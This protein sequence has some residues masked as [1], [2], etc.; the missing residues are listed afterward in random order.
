MRRYY[1]PPLICLLIMALLF[2]S[3]EQE[4]HVVLPADPEPLSHP[5][6]AISGMPNFSSTPSSTFLTWIDTQED[7]HHLMMTE[8]DGRQWTNAEHIASGKD[9]FVNW[10]DFP[11]SVH[12][13]NGNKAAYWLQ[14]SGEGTF[15]YDI[16]WKYFRA[17]EWSETMLLNTDGLQAEHGFASMI[18]LKDGRMLVSWLDGRLT[19]TEKHDMESHDH[20]GHAGSMTLRAALF[21]ADFNRLEEWSLDERVCDCCQTTL[22]PTENGAVLL[23]RDRSEEEIRDISVKVFDGRAW[24]D[25]YALNHDQW[26]IA[27]CPVNGPS[28]ASDG[29]TLLAAWFT[30]AEQSLKMRTKISL[31]GGKTFGNTQLL[32]EYPGPGRLHT[33]FLKERNTFV[34]VWMENIPSEGTWIMAAELDKAGTL[35]RKWPVVKGTESRAGGFPRVA[36]D[37]GKLL[38]AWTEDGETRTLQTAQQILN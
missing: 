31:D 5:A 15:H 26:N 38:F 30:G 27:G 35:M 29:D 17:G 33:A 34:V 19:V 16:A 3:C 1:H 24:S 37:G 18:A 12:L 9:W 2:V 25:S 13:P 11:G 28:L 8:W 6:S 14:K 20:S 4:L 32:N 36:W 22:A 7:T 21:D 23:Y 10:A